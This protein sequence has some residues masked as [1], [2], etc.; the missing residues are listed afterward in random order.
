[1]DSE[2][3]IIFEF[4]FEIFFV[5][6]I[7]VGIGNFIRVYLILLLFFRILPLRIYL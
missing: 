1:M 5:W 4:N 2:E 7:K 3:I 6:I